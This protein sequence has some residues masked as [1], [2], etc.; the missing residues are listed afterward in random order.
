[1]LFLTAVLAAQKE[2]PLI[3]SVIKGSLVD[4]MSEIS[5]LELFK[6]LER[7]LIF[8]SISAKDIVT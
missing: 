3:V 7:I 2:K 8:Q 5:N 6:D 4:Y 1:M